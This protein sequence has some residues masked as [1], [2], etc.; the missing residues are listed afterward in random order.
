MSKFLQ[1]VI[2]TIKRLYRKYFINQVEP[3]SDFVDTVVLRDPD[4][5]ALPEGWKP[6]WHLT[7]K[8]TAVVK[9]TDGL[10]VEGEIKSVSART[11]S[12]L[13]KLGRVV[14]GLH[15]SA[16]YDQPAI[17]VGDGNSAGGAVLVMTTTD[18]ETGER[19][20]ATIDEKRPLSTLK[21]ADGTSEVMVLRTP[22][23]GFVDPKEDAQKT[24][25]RETLEECGIPTDP[26]TYVGSIV[27]DRAFF[28]A[29]FYTD[30]RPA[31]YAVAVYTVAVDNSK[32]IPQPDGSYVF[33]QPAVV[34]DG[35]KKAKTL[36]AIF[37]NYDASTDTADGIAIA[38]LSKANTFLGKVS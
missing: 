30:G 35:L 23:G 5:V 24:S 31:K 36:A 19:L 16:T 17:L 28:P 1:L 32:L 7:V 20:F 22:P 25:Q 27:A 9:T 21:K 34:P 29:E 14:Y 26:S 15:P 13:S 38:A 8:G 18:P 33:P 4:T 37:R 11:I 6:G 2:S 10:I 3:L 12:L